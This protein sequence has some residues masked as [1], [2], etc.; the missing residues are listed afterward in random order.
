MNLRGI[1][2]NLLTVFEAVYEEGNQARAADRLAMTQ[3]AVSSAM[4]R[5][6]DVVTEDLFVPGSR[7]V[8]ATPAA[9]RLYTHVHP[10]L[11]RV[12][13]GIRHEL[14]FDPA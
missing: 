11:D 7:G 3:P 4:S 14:E 12:R 1:D 9:D 8:T 13:D 2:L 5:L 10:A 6:S